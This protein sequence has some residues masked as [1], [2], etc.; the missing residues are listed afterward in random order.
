MAA[1]Q[2]EVSVSLAFQVKTEAI[3]SIRTLF[4][5]LEAEDDGL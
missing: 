4:V 1:R 3:S 5:D 2:N